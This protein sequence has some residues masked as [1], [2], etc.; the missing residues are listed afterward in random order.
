MGNTYPADHHVWPKLIILNNLNDGSD[1][2]LC[3]ISS[4][5]KAHCE[6]EFNG[7]QVVGHLSNYIEMKFT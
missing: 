4:V 1:D 6:Y 5:I 3:Q 2:I 7:N